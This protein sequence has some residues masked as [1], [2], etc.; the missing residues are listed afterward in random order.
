MI[1]KKFFTKKN[2]LTIEQARFHPERNKHNSGV[3]YNEKVIT[4]VNIINN[5]KENYVKKNQNL[6]PFKMKGFNL[7]ESKY[8][9]NFQK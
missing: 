1:F 6:K 7:I 2:S 8:Y 4:I 3:F 5:N 9:F